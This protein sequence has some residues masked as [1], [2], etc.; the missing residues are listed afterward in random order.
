MWFQI[1]LP[2][3]SCMNPIHIYVP[4][5]YWVQESMRR[6]QMLTVCV[7]MMWRFF[8]LWKRATPLMAMLFVSV[9]PEVNTM[10]LESAPMRSA[11][12][13]E[14]SFN[15]NAKDHLKWYLSSILHSSLGL[16]SISMGP[17]MGVTILICKIRQHC[18]KNSRVN[19]CRSL[20]WTRLRTQVFK[21]SESKLTCISK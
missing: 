9:A 7:V 14:T 12:C 8:S 15:A 11:K 4:T 20:Q 21:T 5:I 19:G 13:Y 1:L 16:P 3:V 18:I 6:E 2:R 10:S 17:T